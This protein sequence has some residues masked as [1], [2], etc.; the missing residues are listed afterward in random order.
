M[1]KILLQLSL[2]LLSVYTYGSGSDTFH[3]TIKTGGTEGQKNGQ[4]AYIFIGDDDCIPDWGSIPLQE[5]NF[6]EKQDLIAEDWTYNTW[7]CSHGTLRFLIKFADIA[8]IPNSATITGAKLI[9]YGDTP[10]T[11]GGY[12]WWGNSTFPGSS[13]PAYNNLRVRKVLE[14]WDEMTVTWDD[15]P[16]ISSTD[17][18]VNPSYSTSRFNWNLVDSSADLIS[19]VQYWVANPAQNFGLSFQLEDENYYNAV[20]FCSSEHDKPEKWPELQITYVIPTGINDLNKAITNLSVYP[21]PVNN[22]VN[23]SFY[24]K[25]KEN[26]SFNILDITGRVVYSK[27]ETFNAGNQEQSFNTNQL[28]NGIYFIKLINDNNSSQSVKFVKQ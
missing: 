8:A 16:A 27:Q 24:L 21:N 23:I 19:M 20:F 6:G 26:I 13:F 22:D 18:Y 15:Q 10:T 14:N 7:G 11:I 9:L 4:D 3:L 1:K 17:Y 5:M 25:N 2:L 28:A 12:D